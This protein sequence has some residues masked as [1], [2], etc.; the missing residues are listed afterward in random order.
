MFD[1][2]KGILFDM[3]GTVLD[4]EALFDNAQLL[5]LKEFEID[6]KVE[7][8]K[9]FK[10]MSYKDFYPRFTNKFQ[11]TLDVDIIRFKIRNY[12]HDI[13]ET[14]LK[15]IEGFEHFFNHYIKPYNYQVGLVTNTTRLSYQKIQKCIN[16]DDY[17]KYVITVNESTEPKPSPAPYFQAM[18]YLS[19][20][21]KNTLIIE[22]SNTGLT[23]AVKTGA[24]VIG[25]TTTLNK[26]QMQKINKN[27]IVMNT[28]R[29]ISVYFEK[30]NF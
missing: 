12:L 21:A 8:L 13:M 2:I 23:S 17:F 7:D 10:G 19:L 26:E 30:N 20:N 28:Y 9:E 27:I 22:D 6:A 11:L 14:R 29:D 4:S 16:I 25:I 15:F 5:F 24:K 1:S 3:D 18:D